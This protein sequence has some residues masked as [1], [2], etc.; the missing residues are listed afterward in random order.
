MGALGQSEAL[1]RSVGTA[2]RAPRSVESRLLRCRLRKLWTLRKV[3]GIYEF[4]PG[5]TE[6]EA[7]QQIDFG[8]TE[9][10]NG[11]CGLEMRCENSRPDLVNA[12]HNRS[13]HLQGQVRWEADDDEF[14]AEVDEGRQPASVASIVHR[15]PISPKAVVRYHMR[16]QRRVSVRTGRDL[17]DDLARCH[18][19]TR[20]HTLEC[21]PMLVRNTDKQPWIH[22]EKK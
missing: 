21:P 10:G 12:R 4:A 3:E 16:N 11:R 22:L 6:L 9:R 8:G 7:L 15:D 14:G 13:K 18:T 19:E 5:T 2:D 1:V 17:D 20:E